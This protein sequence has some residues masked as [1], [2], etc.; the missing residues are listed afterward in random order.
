[1]PQIKNRAMAKRIKKEKKN[2]GVEM[3]LYGIIGRGLD[4]DA[5]ALIRQIE[6]H[7]KNGETSFTFYV[8]SDGGEVAQGSALFNYLDRTDIDVTWVVDGIAASMMAVLITNPKHKV[9][10]ARYAKFMYHRVCGYIYGNSDETRAAADMMDNFENTL[11]DMM[12]SRMGISADE[13]RARYFDGVDHWLNA[14]EAVLEGLCDEI[15]NT[16]KDIKELEDITDSRSAFNYYNN[17]IINLKRQNMDEVKEFAAALNMAD[18]SSVNEVLDGVRNAVNERT[19]LRQELEAER[20]KVTALTNQVKAMEGA[21]VTALIDSAIADKRIGE[22]DRDAYTRLA[23][24]DFENTEKIL[25]KMKPVGKIKDQLNS[26]AV[27]EAEAG[28]DWDKYHRS[29]KLE[30]LK[31]NNPERYAELYQAKFGCAPQNQ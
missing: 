3:Y 23:E 27:N 15:I 24:Q 22:D 12:A 13:I 18:T 28:W 1:L 29:G 10:A 19:S 17:Q 8:N 31:N 26:P 16:N 4:I 5:N 25:N 9:K 6:E 7:R 11:V 30:N 2:E 21:K 20:A 14:E